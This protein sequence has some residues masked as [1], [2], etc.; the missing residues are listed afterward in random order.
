M[1][2]SRNDTSVFVHML[3]ILMIMMRA[4]SI[5]TV[6]KANFEKISDKMVAMLP[7]QNIERLIEV[8]QVN[9]SLS[10]TIYSYQ[11]KDLKEGTSRYTNRKK[12]SCLLKKNQ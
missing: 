7:Y 2:F 9:H 4:K 3:S 8:L 1:N 5:L 6:E 12:L 11:L 10:V